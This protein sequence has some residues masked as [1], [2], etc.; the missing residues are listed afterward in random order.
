VI[1]VSLRVLKYGMLG[2]MVFIASLAAL[3]Y[4][5][6]YTEKREVLLTTSFTIGG[7]EQKFK[8]FYLSAPAEEF[9][10]TFNVSKG[11]IKFSAWDAETFENSLGWFEYHNGTAVEKRQVWFYEGNNGTAGY[12]GTVGDAET[13][14]NRIWYIHFYNEDPYEKEVHIRVTKVWK[15][16]NYQNWINWLKGNN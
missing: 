7:Q 1:Y 2:F 8:A 16:Q 10:I 11:S 12:R 4:A 5:L 14:A 3:M 9:Y 13:D 15:E 6:A